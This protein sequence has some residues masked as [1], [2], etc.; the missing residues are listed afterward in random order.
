MD[1]C[2]FELQNIKKKC[3]IYIAK[4]T[5]LVYPLIIMVVLMYV[6]KIFSVFFNIPFSRKCSSI[7]FPRS[8]N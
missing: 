1:E 8:V 4:T 6:Q 2:S 7:L 5:S 3:N